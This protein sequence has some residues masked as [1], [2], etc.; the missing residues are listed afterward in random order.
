MTF[1]LCKVLMRGAG[2][3][4]D[5]ELVVFDRVHHC[6]ESVILSLDHKDQKTRLKTMI[7]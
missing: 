3:G 5:D 6:H 1:A 4:H 2:F 7:E